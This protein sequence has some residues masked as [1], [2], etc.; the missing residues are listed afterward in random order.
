MLQVWPGRGRALVE[1]LNLMKHF[2]RRSQQHQAGG[3]VE[4]E[5]A[6]AVSKLALLCP[7]CRR[8]SRI[9]WS[10]AGDGGKQR[11]CRR[12]REVL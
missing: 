3:V 7:K 6:I 12:C 9:S 10:V 5:G 8:P 11:I 2:E 4:R 1:R